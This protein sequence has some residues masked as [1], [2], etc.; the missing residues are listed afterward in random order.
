MSVKKGERRASSKEVLH[1]AHQIKNELTSYVFQD[2]G[3]EKINRPDFPTDYKVFAQNIKSD[4]LS[5]AKELDA[6]VSNFFSC[7]NVT[8]TDFKYKRDQEI[9]AVAA[10]YKIEHLCMNLIET[11]SNA[12]IKININKYDRLILLIINEIKLIRSCKNKDFQNYKKT[13]KI[14]YAVG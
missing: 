10:C 3:I 2:L 4:L 1:T 5:T 14:A 9:K 6:R 12:G 13:S 7:K 11:F 8:E